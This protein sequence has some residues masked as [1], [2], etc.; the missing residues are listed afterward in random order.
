MALIHHP[1]LADVV[2]QLGEQLRFK[3]VLPPELFEFAILLV[4]RHWTSQYEWVAHERVARSKTTLPD[5]LIRAVQVGAVPE[6]MTHEQ[7]VV[8]DFVVRTMKAGS[9]DN[10]VYD[11]AVALFGRTGVLDLIATCG[12]YCLI[13]IV[14]NTAEIPLPKDVDPPL[15]T[16][17]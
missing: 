14:L 10:P 13:A 9:P 4:A 8:H 3:S 16:L 7:R 2:Q 6:G 11:E 15:R 5:A 17:L 12:Y 1:D